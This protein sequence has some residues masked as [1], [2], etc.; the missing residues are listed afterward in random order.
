MGANDEELHPWIK[1]ECVLLKKAIENELPTVGICLG[2]QLIAKAMGA[3]VEKN[4]SPEVGWFPIELTEEGKNDPILGSAGHEPTVYHW[5]SDTFHLPHAALLLGKSKACER[6]AYKIGQSTYG[7]QF[8]PEAD[9][10]LVQEWMKTHEVE[11]EI[12]ELQRVSNK[13]HI[14]NSETQKNHSLKHEKASLKL[15]SALT[16]L[17]VKEAYN[18][19]DC[20]YHDHLESWSVKKTTLII[21]FENS[22]GKI[23]QGKGKIVDT[24]TIKAGEFII[25]KEEN[26]ILWPIRQDRIKK[27]TAI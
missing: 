25:F 3:K 11:K 20:E 7:F 22:K 21:E 18:P 12:Q 5:H 26:S 16:S 19:I 23:Q 1:P 17:F 15:S 2:G 8:H 9:H 27:L 6:Q 10:H 4:H 13:E 24:F 14:Q